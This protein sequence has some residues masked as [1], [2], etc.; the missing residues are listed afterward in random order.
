MQMCQIYKGHPTTVITT[1]HVYQLRDKQRG[2]LTMRRTTREGRGAGGRHMK[3]CLAMLGPW[4]MALMASHM[5]R[6][7]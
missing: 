6:E 5:C 4:G 7:M 3:T 1:K 2:T